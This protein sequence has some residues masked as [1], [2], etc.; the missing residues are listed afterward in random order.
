MTFSELQALYTDKSGVGNTPENK[1]ECVGLSAVW[2][3]ALG[4]PHVWGN[5][6][7]L[8]DNADKSQFIIVSNSPTNSPSEGDVV[9]LGK[10]F[11]Q[12][13]DSLGVVH[14]NG[15][16]GIA[17]KNCN[18]AI[19]ELFEA[20]DPVGSPPH[21]KQYNY[22]SCI[23]WLHARTL[24][25]TQTIEVPLTVEQVSTQ[26][27]SQTEATSNCLTQ[28][29]ETTEQNKI[30]QEQLTNSSS[31]VIV[32]QNQLK[33][34]QSKY[35]AS[36]GSVIDLKKQMEQINKE[37]GDYAQ[38]ALDSEKLANKYKGYIDAIAGEAGVDVKIT[39]D[40]LIENILQKI[41]ELKK[42]LPQPVPLS[43][44][45]NSTPSDNIDIRKIL[46][47]FLSWFIKKNEVK[48]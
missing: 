26:L 33:E 23:G 46:S 12:Y 13:T 1:G 4:L 7:N 35:E 5:A 31:Q 29:K 18:D 39:D 37:D 10:P 42:P 20:N 25:G 17:T 30:I 28:L 36:A 6:I 27:K 3:E 34:L 43:P 44:I 32:L 8:L 15:H 21:I 19:L 9:V 47:D 24:P 48:T 11:G 22:E 14:Y 16:T 45:D 41:S 2:I 40:T 38:K